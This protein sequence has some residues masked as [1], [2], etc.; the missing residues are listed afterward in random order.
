MKRKN[1]IKRILSVVLAVCMVGGTVYFGNQ[2]KS[3]VQAAPKATDSVF[4]ADSEEAGYEKLTFSD[5]GI[6]DGDILNGTK[7]GEYLYYKAQKEGTLDGILFQGKFT[8]PTVASGATI[9]NLYLGA[10]KWNGVLL[11][12]D[13]VGNILLDVNTN[14]KTVFTAADRAARNITANS[15]VNLRDGKEVELAISIKYENVNETAK[16]TDLKIGVWIN[17][18]L[19]SGGYL[20][21]KGVSLSDL[22]RS[23]NTYEQNTATSV[24]VKSIATAQQPEEPEK[25]P[26]EESEE[27]GY[28]KLTFQDFGVD[29]GEIL[30]GKTGLK[31]NYATL[32]GNLDGILFQGKYEFPSL[33][34]GKQFGNIYLGRPDWYCIGLTQDRNGNILFTVVSTG[35]TIVNRD[36]LNLTQ[37]N[38]DIDLR[39][40]KELEIAISVKYENTNE[41]AGTTD[42]RIGVWINGLLQQSDYIYAK[43]VKLSDLTRCLHTYVGANAAGVKVASIGARAL[44]TIPTDLTDI[45]LTDGNIPDGNEVTYGNFSRL[46]SLNRTL[47]SANM[48]FNKTGAR[49]HLGN[50][51]GAANAYG[52]LAIRLGSSGVLVVGNDYASQEGVQKNELASIGLNHVLIYPGAAG[53]GDTFAGKDFLLQVS[54]EFVDKDGDGKENDIKL[55]IFINGILYSN[56]YL[57]ILNE[58]QSLGT[59]VNMNG[60]NEKDFARFSSVALKELTTTDLGIKDGSYTKAVY[61]RTSKASLDQTAITAH[62][63]F[64]AQ[65]AGSIGFGSMGKGIQFV[66]TSNDTLKVTHVKADGT[67]TEIAKLQLSTTAKT[68]LRTTYEFIKAGENKTNLKLGV[69]INGQLYH[70][71][72]FIVEDVDTAVLTRNMEIVPSGSVISIAADIHEELTLRDFMIADK[73][74]SAYGGKFYSYEGGNY[75]NGAF[76]ARLT[77]S[78][79]T[80]KKNE[81][82]IYVGGKKWAGLRTELGSDGKLVISFVHADTVQM[83]LARIA[84]EEAGMITFQDRAF[85]YR[86]TFDIYE[87][88]KGRLDVNI[89]VYINGTLCTG[90][91]FLVKGVEAE[92][93]STGFFTYIDKNGG[94]ITMQSTSPEVDFTIYGFTKDWKKTLGLR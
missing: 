75:N 18:Q 34:T 78:D 70:Y 62:V 76:C 88:T 64:G 49:I 73:K 31:T 6:P 65:G 92:L 93:L 15:P 1:R 82:C 24:A 79:E 14:K 61:S 51:G 56:E 68:E 47:F 94:Y 54:T 66:R 35:S 7:K 36:L 50:A 48:R 53:M 5:F 4:L 11:T 28:E 60:V 71:Q 87:T 19:Q 41:T 39:E 26:L 43:N 84:P 9:G 38:K 3:V 90:K 59:G 17:G 21:A 80:A 83:R 57:Y 12:Q 10:T 55:G 46:D 22:S 23:L 67:A 77:F 63:R 30:T 58:A 72:Y 32:Q 16:T 8:F 45:T 42:L 86:V 52:G 69:Y 44:Q 27:A 74:L 29:N 13:S 2:E 40:N 37:G 91:H 33:E 85:T 81:D 20:C 25:I 89:G